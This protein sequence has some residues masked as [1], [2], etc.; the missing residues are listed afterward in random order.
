MRTLILGLSCLILAATPALAQKRPRPD[1]SGHGED[2]GRLTPAG[3]LQGGWRI[4]RA[5]DPADAA[6][7]GL[8]LIHDGNLVEG[9]YVLFQPF[10]GIEMPLPRPAAEDCE[11]IDLGGQLEPESFVRQGWVRLILRPGADGLP[12]VLDMPVAGDALRTGTYQ[13]PN[14]DAPITVT[15]ERT[16]E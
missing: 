13:S 5:G 16:P 9:S 7:M 10:C 4:V 3:P 11:F 8:H 2:A 6:V 14:M 1:P 12:H 15:F